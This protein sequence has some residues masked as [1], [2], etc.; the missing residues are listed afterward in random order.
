[1]NEER[2]GPH[3]DS[4]DPVAAPASQTQGEII[5][6]DQD[7]KQGSDSA[8]RTSRTPED[9]QPAELKPMARTPAPRRTNSSGYAKLRRVKSHSR[10]PSTKP[11]FPEDV[12]VTLMSPTHTAP[13]RIPMSVLPA[14][15]RAR[16]RQKR[17]AKLRMRPSERVSDVLPS[18]G[19]KSSFQVEDGEVS[20][21]DEVESQL[22]VEPSLIDLSFVAN[23]FWLD[24]SGASRQDIEAIGDT[25]KLYPLTIE[26]L[27]S[28]ADGREDRLRVREKLDMFHSYIYI[29]LRTEVGLIHVVLKRDCTIT[30]HNADPCITAARARLMREIDQITDHQLSADATLNA[31]KDLLNGD[32]LVYFVLD[33]LIHES[34]KLA[35]QLSSEVAELANQFNSNSTWKTRKLLEPAEHARVRIVQIRT[36]LK[37]RIVILKKLCMP[38]ER[39]SEA[40]GFQLM[41]PDDLVSAHPRKYLSDVLDHELE[42]ISSIETIELSLET[43]YQHYV[44][45][46]NLELAA[47]NTIMAAHMKNLSTIATV[48]VPMSLVAGLFGMNVNVPG[49]DEEGLWV[50]WTINGSMLLIT[51]AVLLVW[52][53]VKRIMRSH[54]RSQ[55]LE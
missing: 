7:H 43:S 15:K 33:S 52:A 12:V 44:T 54:Y 4:R 45:R 50:F 22:T 14:I 20:D 53:L 49:Q 29:V 32:W 13:T 6:I 28:E 26:D 46:I 31:T 19:S 30:F 34:V 51:L 1:M 41:H 27:C 16:E 55:L 18:V 10:T 24:I 42:L 36:G 39:I 48:I 47:S 2:P 35:S 21:M 40:S 38:K 3:E 23:S 5:L 8:E 37:A 17:I 11:L 25:F 9:D